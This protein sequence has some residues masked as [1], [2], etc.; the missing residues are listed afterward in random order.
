MIKKLIVIAMLVSTFGIGNV[1]Y[2]QATSGSPGRQ[3]TVGRKGR[4]HTRRYRR[5]R[6][7]GRRGSS[8]SRRSPKNLNPQPL[9]PE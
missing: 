8:R 7:G 5:H 6:R 9:P 1:T 4:S 3:S 2:A